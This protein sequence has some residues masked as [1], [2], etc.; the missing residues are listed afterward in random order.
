MHALALSGVVWGALAVFLGGCDYQECHGHFDDLRGQCIGDAGEYRVCQKSGGGQFASGPVMSHWV[1]RVCPGLA[2]VCTPTD[3]GAARDCSDAFVGRACAARTIVDDGSGL[4][5]MPQPYPAFADVDGD[6][7]RDAVLLVEGAEEVSVWMVLQDARLHFAKPVL[8]A[9]LSDVDPEDLT[10]GGLHLANLDGV[11]PPDVLVGIGDRTELLL[12]GEDDSVVRDSYPLPVAG[13]ADLDGDGHDE[14]LFKDGE[15]LVIEARL[16][17]MKDAKRV[18]VQL[19]PSHTRWSTVRVAQYGGDGHLDLVVGHLRDDL[20]LLVAAGAAYEQVWQ[21]T[22]RT[23]LADVDGNGSAD[24]LATQE[25]PVETILMDVGSGDGEVL[26]RLDA[27]PY[28]GLRGVADVTGDGEL[29]LVELGWP[30]ASHSAG[31]LTVRSGD[32][33]GDFSPGEVFDQPYPALRAW[34]LVDLDGDR[35]ADLVGSGPEGQVVVI[36]SACWQ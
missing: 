27:I 19:D 25:L 16:P 23:L 5:S 18:S 3:D 30:D 6:G 32:G 2:P 34:R 24:A 29:D 8:L 22:R 12:V 10:V 31:R 21:A 4:P 1:R 36:P 35:Q 15:V 20:V 14:V 17:A 13:A 33:T 28:S 7:D 26:R 9:S 11:G